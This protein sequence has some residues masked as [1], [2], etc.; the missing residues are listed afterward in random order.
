[1]QHEKQLTLILG[2]ASRL[3][4]DADLLFDHKRYASAFALAVLGL[5]EIGKALIRH[6]DAE[7][8]LAKPNGSKS[9]HIRKQAAVSS[10]LLGALMV[11]RFP[12][13]VNW[14]IL[15]IAAETDAFNQ[16]EEGRVF[17][18]IRSSILDKRKQNALYQDDDVLTAVED[19]FAEQHVGAIFKI[20]IEAKE[21]STNRIAQAG[22]RAFYE[23]FLTG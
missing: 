3:L 15:D 2:N 16:S 23:C 18:A 22:G 17:T 20:A 21:A 5:E 12:N 14:D 7:Q 9:A 4:K 19:D 13:G 8:P 10:L 6:W 1:M 11:R